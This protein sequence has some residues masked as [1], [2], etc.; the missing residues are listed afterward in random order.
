MKRKLAAAV[1]AVV[2]LAACGGGSDDAAPSTEAAVQTDAPAETD[3]PVE[4]D[5]PAETDVPA[6]PEGVLRVPGDFAAIQEAV[7]AAVP[8]DLV[9]VSPGTYNEA[10]NVV[11]D[12]IT[13]RGTDRAGVVLDGQFELDNG[14]RV[15]G[16]S[17]VVV[18]NLTA[19]NYTSNGVFFT[20]S[21]GYRASYVTAIRNGDYGVYAF[22][23]ING[24]IGKPFSSIWALSHGSR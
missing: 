3:A 17:G 2:T 5:A 11:T 19:R 24:Q 8:G 9:L 13:I 15:L 7:D 16:A 6:E 1:V 10:V 14:I 18:E 22:D 4:T 20:A 12:E 21:V 23:S